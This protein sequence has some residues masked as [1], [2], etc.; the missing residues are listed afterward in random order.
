MT[1]PT[2]TTG[3]ASGA[4]ESARRMNVVARFWDSSIGKHAVMAVTGII[5]IAFL[6]SHFLANLQVFVGPLAINEYAAS[7]RRLGPLL[8]LARAGLLVALV[9]HVL[10][11]YQLTRRKQTAR[12]SRAAASPD[13]SMTGA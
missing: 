4:R 12:S 5:M 7:L 13:E 3:S 10:A 2:V 1:A 8:W 9:L 6:I 11:A